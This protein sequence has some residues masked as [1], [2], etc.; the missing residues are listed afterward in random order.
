MEKHNTNNQLLEDSNEKLELG[1]YLRE[2]GSRW[3]QIQLV[4]AA[5]EYC[6]DKPEGSVRQVDDGELNVIRDKQISLNADIQTHK[7]G[8][9]H[10]I[11]PLL[12][13]NQIA[14]LYEIKAG[15]ILK[16]LIDETISF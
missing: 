5:L 14:E 1:W 7:L 8:T 10:Q 3:T 13:G 6:K 16:N 4:G 11:K 12:A 2:S 9:I 15:K